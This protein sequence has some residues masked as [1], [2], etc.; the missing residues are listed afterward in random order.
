MTK[1]ISAAANPALANNLINQAIAEKPEAI[2][3][4]V[5]PPL[6]NVV[7][8]PG[9]YVSAAGEVV[10]TAEVRELTGRDEEIITKASSLNKV[11]PIILK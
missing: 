5:L 1:T 9:G 3:V 6:D 8:L 7:T 4:K 2:D 11:F 10:R